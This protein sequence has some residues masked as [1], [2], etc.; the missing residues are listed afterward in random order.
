MKKAFIC[1]MAVIMCLFAA[2]SV[3]AASTK[4]TVKDVTFSISDGYDLLTEEDLL[5]SSE[6]K[7]LLF[8][9]ISK[10]EAHQIQ[11]RETS[12]DFSKEVDS[13]KGLRSEDLVPV[14]QK[15][16][17]DGYDTAEIG[18]HIYLKKSTVSDGQYTVT[19]VTVSNG[20]LYTFTYF[21]A[22]PLKLGEFMGGVTLPDSAFE[23]EPNIL[24]IIFLSIGILAFVV[25]IVILGLSFIKD[26]RRRK[27]EQS[28]NIVSNYIKIKRRKY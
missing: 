10:D 22:D 3:S 26:Y 28:D 17:P 8:A 12:T 27:M 15:L 9:A 25:L 1:V 23:S 5:A 20:K 4:H 18:Q 6:V 19:Y 7:G 2:V 14:G 13:F 11:C 21:G 24:M 16:F